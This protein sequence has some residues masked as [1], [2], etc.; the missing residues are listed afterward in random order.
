MYENSNAQVEPNDPNTPL[1]DNLARQPLKKL[2]LSLSISYHITQLFK[3]TLAIFPPE[4]H[5]F[6]IKNF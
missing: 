1:L 4:K 2:H 3:K 6:Y 5:Q